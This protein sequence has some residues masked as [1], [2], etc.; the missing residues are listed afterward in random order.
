MIVFSV[1]IGNLKMSEIFKLIKRK[2]GLTVNQKIDTF[3]IS[4]I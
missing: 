4:N 3:E 1:F 2:V